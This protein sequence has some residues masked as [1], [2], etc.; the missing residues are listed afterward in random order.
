MKS[1]EQLVRLS[2]NPFYKMSESE[3]KQ[4]ESVKQDEPITSSV[5][6]DSKKKVSQTTLGSAT[7]KETGKLNKHSSDP[8]SE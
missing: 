1:I 6:E 3:V 5:T 8:V 7:V 4:L 2:Q